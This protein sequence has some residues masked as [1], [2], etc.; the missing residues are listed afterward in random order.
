V[1][2]S[3]IEDLELATGG[4]REF[5][6]TQIGAR[7]VTGRLAL[8]VFGGLTLTYGKFSCDIHVSGTL[9]NEKLSF[10]VLLPGSKNVSYFGKDA[11]PGDLLV[12]GEARENDARYR[13]ELEYVVINVD[14]ADVL[15]IVE[16][17]DWTIAPAVLDGSDV[18]KLED[19]TSAHLVKRM[20]VISEKLR[21]GSLEAIGPEAER[22][23]ADEIVLEFV[24]CLSGA[25]SKERIGRRP[26]QDLPR[27]VQRAEDWLAADPCHRPSIQEIS[28]GLDVSSRQL[29][30]A[31]NTEVGMSPAIYLKHYRMTQ[32]RLELVAAVPAE[33]TVTSVAHSWGFWEL[34]RF[35]V[36]YRLSFGE[37]PSQTLRMCP[38]SVEKVLG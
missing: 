11:Q 28:R 32:A 8:S 3:N 4:N 36:E 25:S 35:A 37:S 5:R 9:S 26:R 12:V 19:R 30:R 34:G 15:R 17:E 31:F 18:L 10:G 20:T 27:L 22:W 14:K 24:R 23:L 21:N 6:P 1:A 38:P 7:K 13:S 2:I 33:T 16:A 29:F